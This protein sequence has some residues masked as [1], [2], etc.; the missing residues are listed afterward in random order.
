MGE[1]PNSKEKIKGDFCNEDNNMLG[2][3]LKSH[4]KLN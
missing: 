1:I 2:F 4:Q 3:L